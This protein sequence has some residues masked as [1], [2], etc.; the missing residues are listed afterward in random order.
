MDPTPLN[1]FTHE[2]LRDAVFGLGVLSVVLLFTTSLFIRIF[3]AFN[4]YCHHREICTSLDLT[5]RFM[6]A[7]LLICVVQ[8]IS[9]LIW[10]FALYQI[11][12]VKDLH[13]AML[14]AGSCYTTLGIFTVDLPDGWQSTAFYIAFSGLFSFAL[15]TSS[16]ISMLITLNKKLMQVKPK[17]STD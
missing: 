9:I 7:I 16:M 12:L 8:V 17:V 11:G 3:I 10:T 4:T 2:V 14:F 15:A 1:T 6:L 5:L 13:M